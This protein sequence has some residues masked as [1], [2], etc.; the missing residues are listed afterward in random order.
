MCCYVHISK[1]CS[2]ACVQL[3]RALSHN[4]DK[5]KKNLFT[6]MHVVNIACGA[7]LRGCC[8]VQW[9]CSRQASSEAEF[10]AF[11]S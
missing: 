4:L 6:I 5:K 2:A 7:A 11:V 8:D 10:R 3:N 9:P 1:E